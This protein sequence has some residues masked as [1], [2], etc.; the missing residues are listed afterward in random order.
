MSDWLMRI[1]E[2]APQLGAGWRDDAVVSHGD[3]LERARAWTALGRR[4]AG[5][6]VALYIEDSI[7]FAAALLG[8]WQAEKTVWLAAD[9]LPATRAALARSVTAFWGDY[10]AE[11]APQAPATG[12]R[13]PL[14]WRAIEGDAPVLV[15]HTSGSTGEPKVISKRMLQISSELA[16]LSEAF[17]ALAGEATVLATVSH[18]HI[19]GLLFRVLWPLAS[20]R[21]FA[22]QALTVPEALAPALAQG[23]CVLVASPAQLKRL[24]PEL[25]WSGGRTR[26]RAV[27]SSGGALAPEAAR[28]VHAVLGMTPVEV[29]GSSETGG[30]AWRQQNAD[31]DAGPSDPADPSQAWRA[32]PGVDWRIAD[33]ALEVRSA[34]ADAAHWLRLAD[35]AVAAD[36]GRFL[37]QGRSDR[38][39]KIEQK[40]VSLEA[41]EAQLMSSPLVAE[42]RV[43]A[44]PAQRSDA[45]AR[46]ILAA[47]VVPTACGRAQLDA[48]GKG[49]FSKALRGLLAASTEAVVM[50]RRWRYL[51]QMPTN[52][53]GKISQASL[54]ALLGALAPPPTPK[55]NPN[56]NPRPRMPLVR[57]SSVTGDGVLLELTVPSDL[58]YFDGHFDQAPVLPGVVQVDWAILF[59]RRSFAMA[60]EFTGMQALKF[61]Q[62]I[63]PGHHLQLALRYESAKGSLHFRYVS[64][65]GP[66]ASGRILFA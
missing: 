19:Y 42:A 22:A 38:I 13:C 9:T 8:A 29:Y 10:P 66:H 45:S 63:R 43:I 56:S 2:R 17:G 48:A 30:I 49:A 6:G 15:I 57:S 55:S 16:T 65:A 28:H 37:L 24:P 4:T 54:L 26:L 23:P 12:E 51:D 25:D 46:E 52:A 61:Q 53:Q 1:A 20:G 50:P 31:A 27:F 39:V 21:A 11:N 40:R 59:G 60:P 64:D 36:A 62:T 44:C 18:Q 58:V 3:L 32:L 14:P 7:E 47:F 41:L 5:A 34:Q 35:L 33:G